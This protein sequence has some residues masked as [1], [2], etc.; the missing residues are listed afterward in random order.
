MRRRDVL[1]SA[2]LGL[3][4]LGA[5]HTLLAA[6]PKAA[7]ALPGPPPLTV[8]IAIPVHHGKR[9]LNEYGHFHVLVTNTSKDVVNVW[10]DKFSWGYGNLSFEMVDDAG[11]TTKIRKKP[12]A[13]EKNYPDWLALGAGESYVLG[14]DLFSAQAGDIWEGLPVKANKPVPQHIKLKAVYEIRPDQESTTLNVW[15][16]RLESRQDVYTIW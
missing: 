8:S 6:D 1:A 16:G 2:M 14:V 13:W 12:R 4:A 5:C 9:S 3:P 7:P 11:Q 10:T 15:T